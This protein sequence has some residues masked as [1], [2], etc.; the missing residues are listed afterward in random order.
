[1]ERYQKQRFELKY[2]I[3]TRLVE[4]IRHFAASY[5]ELDPHS[6]G[7]PDPAYPVHSLYMDSPDMRLFQ[8]TVNGHRNR[9]KLRVRYYTQ[10]PESPVFFEIKARRDRV[11][12]KTRAMV[13]R[14]SVRPLLAGRP[15]TAADLHEDDPVQLEALLRFCGHCRGLRAAPKAHVGYRREAWQSPDNS[16][17]VTMDR[18]AGIAVDL[19]ASLSTD[20]AGLKPVFGRELVLEIKFTDRYPLWLTEMVRAFGLRQGGA[21]KYVDGVIALGE[22]LFLSAPARDEARRRM[23]MGHAG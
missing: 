9:Y 4:P 20:L 22:H 3:Q 1:M 18:G 12:R 5:L 6:P 11:I 15:P 17:R 21:A 19:Q 23:A 7:H 13:R 10:D 2:R 16:V 8:S 14:A